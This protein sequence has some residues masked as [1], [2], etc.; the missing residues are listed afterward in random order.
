MTIPTNLFPD[1]VYMVKPDNARIV[2][3]LDGIPVGFIKK[4]KGTS[5]YFGFRVRDNQSEKSLLY[6][7]Y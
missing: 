1:K 4:G 7:K 2:V 6:S 3:E 5:V